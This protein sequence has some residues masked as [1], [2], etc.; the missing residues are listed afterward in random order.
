MKEEKKNGTF[1]IADVDRQDLKGNT[2]LHWAAE[3]GDVELVKDLL[4]NNARA[5][6]TNFAG[7]TPFSKAA[8]AGKV[9]VL[10]AFDQTQ[11]EWR[12]DMNYSRQTPLYHAAKNGHLNVVMYLARRGALSDMPRPMPELPLHVA[13]KNNHFDVAAYII[14][15]GVMLG[16]RNN[17]DKT[18]GDLLL[19]KM[20]D[21]T[22]SPKAILSAARCLSVLKE[23]G[24]GPRLELAQKEAL[25][26]VLLQAIEKVDKPSAHMK[27]FKLI[28]KGRLIKHINVGLDFLRSNFR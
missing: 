18:A 10:R 1:R 24:A 22:S 16:Y 26:S 19:E 25:R 2:L 9:D 11:Y 17:E 15:E 5:G 23:R 12:D 4:K 28:Q 8:E 7:D 14:C 13:I 27:N 21:K 6:L 20:L 3:A